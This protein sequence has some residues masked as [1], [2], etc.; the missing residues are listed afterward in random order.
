MFKLL[1]QSY[2]SALDNKSD[3]IIQMLNKADIQVEQLR[4]DLYCLSWNESQTVVNPRGAGRP[5]KIFRDQHGNI[6]TWNAIYQFIKSLPPHC[7]TYYLSEQISQYFTSISSASA[8]RR[9][10]KNRMDAPDSKLY[11]GNGEPF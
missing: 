5:A 1:I 9:L 10:R 11:A 4:N 7:S 2:A 3:E 8:R 6:I